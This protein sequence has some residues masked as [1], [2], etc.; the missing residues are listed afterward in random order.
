MS[1]RRRIGRKRYDVGNQTHCVIVDSTNIPEG[2]R[3]RQEGG[4]VVEGSL[5]LFHALFKLLEGGRVKAIGGPF[6]GR[7]LC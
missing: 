2:A 4:A 1:L 5:G 3:C 7:T 6:R